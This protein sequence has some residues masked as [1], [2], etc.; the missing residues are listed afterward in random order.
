MTVISAMKFNDREGAIVADRQSSVMGS[1]RK[2]DI[3]EKLHSLSKDR[4][5][6]I[7][8]GAGLADVLYGASV[9]M[10]DAFSKN[11]PKDTDEAM[12]FLRNC[13]V[14]QRR[15]IINSYL[16]NT[17]G[18]NE[19]V[20]QQGMRKIGGDMVP[21]SPDFKVSVLERM[22]VELIRGLNENQFLAIVNDQ[23]G[24][25]ICY[26][27]LSNGVPFRSPRPYEVIGSGS[28]KA[29]GEL[30]SFFDQFPIEKRHEIDPVKGIVALLSATDKA[31][32][33]NI[34]VGGVP[35]IAIIKDGK[36]IQPSEQNSQ[37]ATE[38]VRATQKNGGLLP[39]DF[40]YD[41]VR[42]LIFE[43]EDYKKIDNEMWVATPDIRTLSFFLRGFKE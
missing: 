41:A 22:G 29:D 33:E 30:Y 8:G 13:A 31:S 12:D 3:A 40:S 23:S 37:L 16:E 15:R 35:Q 14:Y 27:S 36:I 17:H 19:T 43:G 2:Y 39:K 38:I 1:G 4:V 10:E 24:L 18:I 25:N 20:L 28:D 6:M 9:M 34:G 42:R 5:R 21:L 26:I 7:Y 32:R 11:V